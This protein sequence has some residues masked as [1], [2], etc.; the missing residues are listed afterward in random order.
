VVGDDH[1]VAAAGE[2]D[3]CANRVVEDTVDLGHGAGEPLRLPLGPAEVV[4]VVG[5][6]EDDEEQLGVEPLRQ[7]RDDLDFLGGRAANHVEVELPVGQRKLVV[8]LE[9]PIAP[10]QLVA[11]RLRV[12]QPL[13]ARRRVE[14]R[15]RKPVDLGRGPGEGHVDDARPPTGAAQPVPEGR[16]PPKAPVHEPELIAGLVALDE[17]PDPVTAC[18]DAADDRRP[19]V[20]CQGMRGGTEDAARPGVA[21]SPE[22]GKLPSG[23]HRVDDVERRRVEPDEG[24]V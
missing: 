21:Q 15:H 6:H 16:R 1:D 17:I 13:L 23:Q 11:Q 12:R 14:A 7:P 5:G 4:D 2:V 3:E 10:A 19:G 20:R 18:V 8:Q 24:Q 22:V 9:R